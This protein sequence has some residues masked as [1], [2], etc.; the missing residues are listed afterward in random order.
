MH[1]AAVW[2]ATRRIKLS[3][4]LLS[5]SC[6][7]HLISFLMMCYLACGLFSQTLSFRYPPQKKVWQVEILGIAWPCFIGWTWNESVPCEVMPEVFKCSIREMKYRLILNHNITLEYIRHNFPLY[8]SF[9]IK[10]ITPSCKTN[11]NQ[12]STFSRF[13]WIVW[14][15]LEIYVYV[16]KATSL[17]DWK[18]YTSNSIWFIVLSFDLFYYLLNSY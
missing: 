6:A 12:T 2:A 17:F 1:C 3:T 11:I 9:H 4:T 8:S 10:P 18:K 5:I 7:I 15:F 13:P 16:N 14:D